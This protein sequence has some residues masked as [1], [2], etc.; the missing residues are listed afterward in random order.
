MRLV[1]FALLAGA[2][3][4]G[5]T[6]PG[7]AA[8]TT[9]QRTKSPVAAGD[10]TSAPDQNQPGKSEIRADSSL[11]GKVASVNPTLRFVVM[12][13]PLRRMPALEQRLNVYR[14]GQKV[15]EVKVTGPTLESTIAGDMI[16]GEA[17]IGDEVRED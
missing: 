10:E 1:L 4:S 2:I 14:G 7:G 5:C 12:D 16:A 8:R 6:T 3:V 13:F 15:G 9:G 11:G 17:Q